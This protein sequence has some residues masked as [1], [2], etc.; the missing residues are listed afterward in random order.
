V[1]RIRGTGRVV[2]RC[3]E[4]FRVVAYRLC[5]TVLCEITPSVVLV[6]S[7]LFGTSICVIPEGSIC[8]GV[9]VPFAV[10]L[11]QEVS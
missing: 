9:P 1:R 7:E 8:I 4:I 5:T 3:C 11:A 6:A 10:T 2:R